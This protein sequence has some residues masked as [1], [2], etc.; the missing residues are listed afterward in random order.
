VVAAAVVLAPGARLPGLADSK[1][2][3]PA[4]REALL[5]RILEVAEGVAWAW[6]GPRTIDRVN[7][8]QASLMAMRRAVARL[9]RLPAVVLVDGTRAIPDL[10]CPQ[11][12]VVDGDA[13]CRSIAAA[14]IVAKVVRDRIMTRCDALYPAYG[15]ASN[16]GYGTREHRLALR[17][18]GPTPLHRLSYRPVAEALQARA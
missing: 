12:T 4:Q 10:P 15:F 1:L 2:L 5:E 17:R 9:P 8:L 16:K 18:L 3:S 7:I 11:E 6:V 13:T 14:S